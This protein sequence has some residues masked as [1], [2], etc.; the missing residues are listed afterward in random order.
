MQIV[1]LV[2]SLLPVACRPNVIVNRR[3]GLRA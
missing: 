3:L 2:I 1:G